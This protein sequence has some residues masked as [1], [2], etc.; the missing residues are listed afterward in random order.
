MYRES[1]QPM[2]KILTFTSLIVNN[3]NNYGMLFAGR[4]V[5]YLQIE[6][7]GSEIKIMPKKGCDEEQKRY[8]IVKDS[9]FCNWL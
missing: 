4:Y 3:Y 8:F 6:V 5:W 7:H 1:E 2:R 9:S